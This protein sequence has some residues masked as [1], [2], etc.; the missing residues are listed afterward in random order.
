LTHA[1]S[2]HSF[3]QRLLAFVSFMVSSFVVGFSVKQV[4]LVWGTSPPIFQLITAW[5]LARLKRAAFLL[6]VRDLWPSFA[7]AMGILRNRILIKASE[8]LETFLYQ[9]ADHIII[10][11]PGYTEHIQARTGKQITLIPNGVDVDQFNPDVHSTGWRKEQRLE[12]KFIVM[13]A[14]AHGLSND[15][16]VVLEAATN[17]RNRLDIQIVLVGDGNEKADS[18]A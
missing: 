9:R 17:L 14:G 6:E 5:L 13:Y 15:L 2:N 3:F 4:D 1:A 8:W 12:D 11:S 18:K 7:I 16:G 10:N